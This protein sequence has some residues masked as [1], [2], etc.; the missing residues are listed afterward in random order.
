M[1]YPFLFVSGNFFP[2]EFESCI[3]FLFH[4]IESYLSTFIHLKKYFIHLTWVWVGSVASPFPN[5]SY[6]FCARNY[7]VWVSSIMEKGRRLYQESLPLNKIFIH[8]L[9]HFIYRRFQKV[10]FIFICDFEFRINLCIVVSIVS[11]IYHLI[12]VL[13]FMFDLKSKAL[14]ICRFGLLILDTKSFLSLLIFNV[15]TTIGLLTL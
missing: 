2:D 7:R 5:I 4:Q 15:G 6:I 10:N 11:N 9:K 1:F 3:H 14:I 8:L 13:V 12:L